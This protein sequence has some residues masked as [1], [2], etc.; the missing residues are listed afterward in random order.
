MPYLGVDPPHTAIARRNKPARAFARRTRRHPPTALR[1][2]PSALP[3]SRRC[4]DRH[5]HCLAVR[6]RVCQFRWPILAR[7]STCSLREK[8]LAAEPDPWCLPAHISPPTARSV[9]D[10]DAVTTERR[11]STTAARPAAGAAAATRTA[12]ARS[13]GSAA[14]AGPAATAATP[15]TAAGTATAAGAT[16]AT[17][18]TAA[19][20]A[21][22]AT[23]AT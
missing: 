12:A 2:R 13:T 1:M 9:H 23:C 22:A 17:C 20:A 7:C 18:A 3:C 6:Q 16:A 15:T 10:C 5:L 8:Y 14:T 4:R 21:T 19:T 11:D